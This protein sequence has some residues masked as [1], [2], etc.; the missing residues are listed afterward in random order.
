MALLAIFAL[1]TETGYAQSKKKKSTKSS[2]SSKKKKSTKNEDASVFKDHLWYGF[3]AG[4][5]TG[6]YQG[7]TYFGAGVSPMVGYKFNKVV[8]AGPRLSTFFSSLKYP[9]YKNIGLFENEVGGFL[10]L[11][12]IRG[13]FLQG[14]LSNSWSQQVTGTVGNEF[15]KSTFS[16]FNQYVGGGYNFG[17]G[18]GLGGMELGLYCNLAVYRDVNTTENPFDYRFTF[19]FRF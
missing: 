19:T 4:L 9:G 13:I 1:A 8:S 6:S 3:G 17:Q 2:K 10:R 14:E 5:G 11:H 15:T 7:Q 18:L 12:L 16:R